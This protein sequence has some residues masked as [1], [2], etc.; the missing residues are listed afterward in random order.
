[1]W[2]NDQQLGISSSVGN[3]KKSVDL[4][5][6]LIRSKILLDVFTVTPQAYDESNQQPDTLTT[7]RQ[8]AA[9]KRPRLGNSFC[10]NSQKFI[11]NSRRDPK[12]S[13]STKYAGLNF[14]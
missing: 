9:H 8:A 12:V 14:R 13:K 4:P 11:L 2:K 6:E 10:S 1:M 3:K 7:H 5:N